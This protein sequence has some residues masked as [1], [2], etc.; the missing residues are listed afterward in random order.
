MAGEHAGQTYIYNNNDW[1]L[2]TAKIRVYNSAL[3]YKSGDIVIKSGIFYSANSDISSG[4]GFVIGSRGT[5]WTPLNAIPVLSAYLD[6]SMPAVTGTRGVKYNK[7]SLNV[8]SWYNASTGR[9]KPTL[10]GWYHI[11]AGARIP[12]FV[13]CSID[14][15]IINQVYL[16][17]SRGGIEGLNLKSLLTSGMCY[18]NGTTTE[19]DIS[20]WVN[21]NN[22]AVGVQAHPSS[23]LN[24]EYIG[25]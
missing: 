12:S 14:I 10:K 9:F 6:V 18:F 23:F 5:T 1:I 4:P 21:I 16:Y 25:Q 3:P 22:G 19:M 2:K 13:E 15:N 7:T 11:T 8:N 24:I 17:G 20:V